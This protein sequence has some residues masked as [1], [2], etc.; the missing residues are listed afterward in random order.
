MR[1]LLLIICL[2]YIIY[3]AAIEAKVEMEIPIVRSVDEY[4]SSEYFAE[5]TAAF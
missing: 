1:E 3:S 4:F 2:F 5:P